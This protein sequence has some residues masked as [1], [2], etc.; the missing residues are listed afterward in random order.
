MSLKRALIELPDDRDS[1]AATREV[2]A[3]FDRHQGENVDPGRISGAIGIAA[4]RV[5]PVLTALAH[6][7]VIDCDGD[8]LTECCSYHPDTVLNLEVRRF[9]KASGEV[10]LG[11]Q[12]RVEKFRGTYGR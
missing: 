12:R 1:V 2:V 6:A 4:L 11:L 9:L 10:D 3:Y 7:H 8:P 5:A